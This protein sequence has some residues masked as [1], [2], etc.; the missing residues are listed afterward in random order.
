VT[1]EV[2]STIF[3]VKLIDGV[4]VAGFATDPYT[5]VPALSVISTKLRAPDVPAASVTVTAVTSGEAPGFIL[6]EK[7]STYVAAPPGAIVTLAGSE[8]L[9]RVV[10]GGDGVSRISMTHEHQREFELTE[11]LCWLQEVTPPFVSLAATSV[12]L[13]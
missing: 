12:A 2:V 9:A 7:K 1:A 13:V 5:V 6:N 10:V 4:S 3:V 8:T 11:T